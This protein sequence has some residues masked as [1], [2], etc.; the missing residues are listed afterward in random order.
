M[1]VRLP[2]SLRPEASIQEQQVTRHSAPY[3]AEPTL[4]PAQHLTLRT[5][6]R[7][8]VVSSPDAVGVVSERGQ[9]FRNRSCHVVRV[10]QPRRPR[11]SPVTIAILTFRTLS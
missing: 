9:S 5:S 3:P 10:E 7:G 1:V 11:V 6:S 4:L 8:K 2:T